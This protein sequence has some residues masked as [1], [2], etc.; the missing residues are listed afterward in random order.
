MSVIVPAQYLFFTGIVVG[1]SSAVVI[2]F[3]VIV[4]CCAGAVI[5]IV[6][7]PIAVADVPLV[8]TVA[9]SYGIEMVITFSDPVLISMIIVPFPGFSIVISS[10]GAIIVIVPSGVSLAVAV[11]V[12]V[13]V[14]LVVAVCP[15]AFFT[16]VHVAT[17]SASGVTMNIIPFSNVIMFVPFAGIVI[18]TSSFA[19]PFLEESSSVIVVP[20]PGSVIVIFPSPITSTVVP[21]AGP[22]M[23]LYFVSELGSV[24]VSIVGVFSATS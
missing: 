24:S 20:S 7:S 22:V 17:L 6:L 14:D 2:V 13:E 8:S 1:V 5:V 9:A 10:A 18:S 23:F 21:M 3:V 11:S 19:V 4:V 15:A 12:L 16:V